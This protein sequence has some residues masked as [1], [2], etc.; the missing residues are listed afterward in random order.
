MTLIVKETRNGHEEILNL[1]LI[2]ELC[3]TQLHGG[4]YFLHAD[5][6]AANSWEQPTVVDFMN[7]FQDTF[8]TMTDKNMVWPRFSPRFEYTLTR[9][10][11]NSGCVAQALSSL[12]HSSTVRQTIKSAMSQQ[13]Q[14]DLGVAGTSDPLQ[15]SSG[16]CPKLDTLAVVADEEPLE[17]WEAEDDVKERPF[18]SAGSQNCP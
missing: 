15:H 16:L 8:Q 7:K 3:E 14:S 10:L 4:R 12:T 17:E 18:E 5:S 1:A 13:L 11:T 6:H 2:C 9:W